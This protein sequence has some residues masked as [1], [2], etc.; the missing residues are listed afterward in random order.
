MRNKLIYGVGIS[1]TGRHARSVNGKHTKP[2]IAWQ[3]IIRRCYSY[4]FQEKFP[5]YID[6]YVCDEWL[7]FQCFAEWHHDNHPKCGNW[8]QLDKDLKIIGNLAYSPD[9]CLFVSQSVNKF[10]TDHRS[11]RGS[12]L[13]G[14]DWHNSSKKFRARCHNPFTNKSDHLGLFSSEIVAHVAWR[15]RKSELAYELAMQQE[16]QDVRDA[17]LRWRFALDN[18]IIHKY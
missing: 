7:E 18:N 8:Y 1:N 6:C 15:K 2:Y 5:T 10:T 17:L 12:F 9:T 3:D 13:I 11:A 4:K 14:V 16:S